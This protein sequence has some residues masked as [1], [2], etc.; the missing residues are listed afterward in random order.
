MLAKL[1]ALLQT[2]VAP[3]ASMSFFVNQTVSLNLG[4]VGVQNLPMSTAALAAF[5]FPWTNA[6]GNILSAL[7]TFVSQL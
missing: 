4:S 6:L 7:S 5:A 3:L 1:D 2:F